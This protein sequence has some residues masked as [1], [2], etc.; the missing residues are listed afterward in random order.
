M[1]TYSKRHFEGI[2]AAIGKNVADMVA[3]KKHFE[4]AACSFRLVCGTP[5]PGLAP[6]GTTPHKMRVRMKRISKSA[7]RLLKNLGVHNIGD[8]Y[9]GPGHLE[10]L[11]VLSWAANH[12]E[13]AVVTAT[14]RLGRLAEIPGI[15]RNPRRHQAAETIPT[16]QV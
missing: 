11:R 7:H 14:R 12:D 2:A 6:N 8:A 3:Q 4:N 5:S 13:D 9:D 10:V 15:T 16:A 1:A